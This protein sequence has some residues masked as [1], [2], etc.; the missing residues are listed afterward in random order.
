MHGRFSLKWNTGKLYYSTVELGYQHEF[1]LLGY[2]TVETGQSLSLSTY[3]GQRVPV[4]TSSLAQIMF[5]GSLLVLSL[6]PANRNLEIKYVFL[7]TQS[8]FHQGD[9]CLFHQGDS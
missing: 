1:R 2:S 4:Y 7:W 6:V 5:T 9:S 3:K 8:S